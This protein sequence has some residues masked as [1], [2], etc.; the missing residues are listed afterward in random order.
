MLTE[1]TDEPEDEVHI[2]LSKTRLE[3][4]AA[5]KRYEDLLL[6]HRQFLARVALIPGGTSLM[7]E[8]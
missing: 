4:A 3:L 2:E 1:P 8:P 5:V 6:H 7:I